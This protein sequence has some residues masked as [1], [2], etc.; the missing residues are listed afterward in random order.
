MGEIESQYCREVCH[1]RIPRLVMMVAEIE[2][3]VKVHR[4]Y[5]KVFG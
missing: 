4:T 3:G 2:E 1:I 5:L